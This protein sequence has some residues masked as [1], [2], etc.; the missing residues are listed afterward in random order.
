MDPN[1]NNPLQLGSAEYPQLQGPG[2]SPDLNAPH[3]PLSPLNE[4]FI[5]N[6]G[7]RDDGQGEDERLPGPPDASSAPSPTEFDPDE[8][9]ETLSVFTL[10]MHPDTFDILNH[11]H[12]PQEIW[13]DVIK[14]V[15]QLYARDAHLLPPRRRIRIPDFSDLTQIGHVLQ[16]LEPDDR[17]ALQDFF[18]DIQSTI[19]ARALVIS[20]P[21]DLANTD[22]RPDFAETERM[23]LA[24][25]RIRPEHLQD[26]T[27]FLN[28]L[29]QE[30]AE[31]N[32]HQVESLPGRLMLD[33]FVDVHSVISTSF[34][35]PNITDHNNIPECTIC[36]E[37][38]RPDHFI[39]R[40]PCHRDHYF[41]LSCLESWLPDNFNCPLCRTPITIHIRFYYHA[42]LPAP[43][44]VAGQDDNDA[45]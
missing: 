10:I 16:T 26:Y 20:D 11:D 6:A 21:H 37:G 9:P 13:Q 22:L 32:S 1:T 27:N 28:N 45:D 24:L 39:T 7:P 34:T 18:S 14:F 12:V 41:H 15:T 38:Y 31:L 40:L 33:H 2:G 8:P 36:L 30:Y 23:R 4:S 19:R 42:P 3:P 25:S 5:D 35:A 29:M 17:T 43:L 44:P